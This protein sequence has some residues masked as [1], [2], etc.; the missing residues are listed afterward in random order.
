MA[1]D[2]T[3]KTYKRRFR[4]FLL[5]LIGLAPNWFLLKILV[6]IVSW[7]FSLQRHIHKAIAL[8]FHLFTIFIAYYEMDFSSAILTAVLPGISEIFWLYYLFISGST[9]FYPYLIL[10]TFS[11]IFAILLYNDERWSLSP[12]FS[13]FSRKYRI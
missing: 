13:I 7:F 1:I 8:I 10:L 4:Y 6:T 3:K 5:D 9:F 12:T 11:P 2:V